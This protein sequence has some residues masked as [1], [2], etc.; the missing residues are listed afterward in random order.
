M[1]FIYSTNIINMVK[2]DTKAWEKS[3]LLLSSDS[4]PSY[5]LDLVFATAKKQGFDGID[6]A[7]WKNFD[8]WNPEY[9]K[10]LSEK[11]DFQVLNIQTS[12]NLNTKEMNKALDLCEELNCKSISI[13]APKYF[14]YKAFN[15]IKDNIGN[16]I[17]NNKDIKFSIINPDGSSYFALPLP[18]YRFSNLVE[19]IKKYWSYLALDI[20]N[21]DEDNMEDEFMRKLE[22]FAPYL[23]LTYLSDKTKTG[24][25][26]QSLWD[27]ILKIP[28]LLKKLNKIWYKNNFSIK[29]DIDKKDLSDI[30]KVKL[31]LKKNISFFNENFREL[32]K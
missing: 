24:K 27:G 6:L 15:F 7:I 2:K 25:S 1:I 20:S 18:K 32:E 14:N 10:D 8:S 3:L 22:S 11:H 5:G 21:L 26:H 12:D 23:S 31:I 28:A 9:V 30:D 29:I 16:Y 13:N 19:I 17:E 4:L